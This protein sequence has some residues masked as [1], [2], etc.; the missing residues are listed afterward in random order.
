MAAGALVIVKRFTYRGDATEEY[1]N[2]YFYL[3]ADP[4]DA[5]AWRAFFDAVVA[6]EKKLYPSTVNVIGGYGYDSDSDT[7][8]AI[9][10]LDLTVSPNVVVP[11]TYSD[12]VGNFGAGDAAVWVRWGTSRFNSKGKRIYCRKYFHPPPHAL[13]TGG[14]AVHGTW[15]TAANAYAAKWHSGTDFGNRTIS[16]QGHDDTIVG[17]AVSDYIT[18]RTLKRRGKRP[19]S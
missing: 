11:G 12:A 17:H 8:T 1:A 5:T 10:S 14:D 13:A 3:G 2:R 4:A 16:A 18:T 6:E 19:G 9:W 7:A 15:K